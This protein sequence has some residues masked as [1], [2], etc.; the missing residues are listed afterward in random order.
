MEYESDEDASEDVLTR[1][2]LAEI[3]MEYVNAL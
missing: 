2:E 1:G 3:L